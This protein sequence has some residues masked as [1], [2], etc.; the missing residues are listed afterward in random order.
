M[1]ASVDMP[2]PSARG[3]LRARLWEGFRFKNWPRALRGVFMLLL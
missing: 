2:R 3:C 1:V